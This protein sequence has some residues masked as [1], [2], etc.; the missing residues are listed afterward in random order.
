M[1]ALFLV[2]ALYLQLGRGL[3][4]LHAGLVFTAMAAAYLATSL[5]A[6]AL[7]LRYGR[8]LVCAG[9]LALAAGEAAL[10][11][12]VAERGTA[13]VAWLVPSLALIGAGMGLC[14]TPLTST[15]LA[16]VDPQRAGAV[17]GALSTM[18]QVGNAVGVAITGVIF[19]GLRSNGYARAF[20]LSL[21]ELSAL[22]LTVAILAAVLP[23]RARLHVRWD[24]P[25]RRLS[26]AR[27][28]PGLADRRRQDA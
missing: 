2:L 24:R 25:R 17:T 4:A 12:T 26:S 19:F 15:V 13:S 7:T 16:H 23:G 20:E 10:L 28:G 1:A 11:V 18:Q 5:R 21:A 27:L 22:L 6:P 14:V 3:D 9:A 8:A